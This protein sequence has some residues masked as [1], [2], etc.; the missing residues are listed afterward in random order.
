ME[1]SDT[2][3]SVKL[4]SHSSGTTLQY[5]RVDPDGQMSNEENQFYVHV[6]GDN[7]FADKLGFGAD[8]WEIGK[9]GAA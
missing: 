4:K 2:D 7:V 5:L 8:K 1:I 6:N 9:H 3:L